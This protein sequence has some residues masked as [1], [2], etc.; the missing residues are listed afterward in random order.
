MTLLIIVAIVVGLGLTFTLVFLGLRASG[1]TGGGGSDVQ[2]RLEEFAGRTT[3]L[4]LEE[5]EMSQPFSQ[6]VIR[7]MLVRLGNVLSRMA[8]KNAKAEA[9][10]Q[11]ELAGRPNGWGATEFLGLRIFVAV[12]LG[13]LIFLVT[14][15]SPSLDATM[16]LL[17]PII[18]AA[19]GFFLPLLWLRTKINQR[20][21][22]IVKGLPDAMDLL[23]IAVEAGMGFDGA[24][25]KVAEKWDNEL[26]RAF[27]KVVQEMRLGVIRREALRNMSNNMDVP[28]VTSFVAA[29]IQADQLGVSIAKILRVQSE[30]MRVKRRQRAEEQANKAP[31]KMLFPMVFLIFPALFVVLLGPAVLILM[32]TFWLQQ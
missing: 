27:G 17:A 3:P 8:P 1:S 2:V 13:V 24:L 16:K 11:L 23:T 19:L 22:E 18:A 5:I 30:Q 10:R 29:I 32:E 4:T 9:E 6:R 26:S 21:K 28:D 12:V 20:K 14:S 15:I 31:I 25:Q 7:P